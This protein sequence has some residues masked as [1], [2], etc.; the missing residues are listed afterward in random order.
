M[1]PTPA[2]AGRTAAAAKVLHLLAYAESRGLPRATLIERYHL[3]PRVL[4]DVDG[5]VPLE[6]VTTLWEELPGLLQDPDMP[7][8][9]L[10][11]AAAADPPLP[12]LLF[13]SS[14]TLGGA[15]Q[16]MVRYERL[17]YDVADEPTSELLVERDRA[18]IRLNHERCAVHPPAGAVIYTMAAVLLLA[19]ESTGADVRPLSVATRFPEPRDR[20]P[21]EALF[22]APLRFGAPRDEFSLR[23]ADLRLPHPSASPILLSI[24]ERHAEAA[25]DQLP[26]GDPLLHR[27]RRDVRARLPDGELSLNQLCRP[28]GVSAR[29]LQRRL[30]AEGTSLRRIIDEER[31]ALALHHIKDPRRPL[32]DIAMLL[33]FSDQSAFTRAF[34][35]WTDRSPTEWRRALA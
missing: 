8:H 9:L 25:M 4:T 27:L 11:H 19:R 29:T 3:D 1:L 31:R 15:L 32:T 35:R 14:P 6:V 5:R 7:L 23:A 26:Q 20:A 33:G 34:A 28:L 16:R 21:Y 12:V 24:T 10:A 22:R 2:P 13:R 18:T 30:E 17:G